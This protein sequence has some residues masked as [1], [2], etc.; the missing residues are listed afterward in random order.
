MQ[1]RFA[2]GIYSRSPRGERPQGLPSSSPR[3]R[4]AT[5]HSEAEPEN[6]EL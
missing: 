6:Q 2:A 3:P 5:E 4:G 1:R